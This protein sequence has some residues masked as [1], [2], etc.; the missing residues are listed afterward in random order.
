MIDT[1]GRDDVSTGDD[2]YAARVTLSER[3]PRRAP[4]SAD[5]RRDPERSRERI[6]EAAVEEFAAHG[7]AG[8]RVSRIARQARVNA[9]LI[10]YYFDGKAGLYRELQRR[11]QG[12][13]GDIVGP[14]QSIDQIA[15]GFVLAGARYR[16]WSRLLAWEALG[17]APRPG[18][19]DDRACAGGSPSAEPAGPDRV[20]FLRQQVADLRRRQAEGEFPADID[21]EHL[22][23][24][25]FAMS[26]APNV[27]PNVVRHIFGAEPDSVEFRDAYAEQVSRMLRHLSGN[28]GRVP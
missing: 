18:D 2:G 24:A 9:Q 21:P 26:S 19:H 1:I 7:Y 20:E 13:T 6:V 15:A 14:G 4:A 25:L 12:E 11:W 28:Q 10:S 16:S 27:L 22:L 3:R 5:R 23:L 8:A 17:D